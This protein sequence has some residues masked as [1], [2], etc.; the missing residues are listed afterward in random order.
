MGDTL[1]FL[2]KELVR[3][4]E[5]RRIHAFALLA[6]RTRRMRE[7]LVENLRLLLTLPS[8]FFLV[9]TW[10]TVANSTPG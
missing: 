10:A 9:V 1:D 2:S 6:E 8:T 5:Q 7:V 4:Q 3:L